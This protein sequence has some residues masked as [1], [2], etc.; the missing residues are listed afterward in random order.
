M[1]IRGVDETILSRVW[2]VEANKKMRGKFLGEPLSETLML[3]KKNTDVHASKPVI[4]DRGEGVQREEQKWSRGFLSFSDRIRYRAV[5][6]NMVLRDSLFFLL[7]RERAIKG[8]HGALDLFLDKSRA[9]R[10]SVGITK[11]PAK[12]AENR[13]ATAAVR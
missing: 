6:G 7:C 10:V 13:G 12:V 11:K 5:I 1:T 9:A 8:E 4:P 2:F 3:I